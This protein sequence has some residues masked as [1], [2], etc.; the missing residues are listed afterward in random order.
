[1]P[2]QPFPSSFPI[3]PLPNVVLFPQ[4]RLPL[5][6]FEPRYREM[7]ADALA[8][9][10]VIGMVLLRPGESHERKRPAVFDVGCAGRISEARRLP[11]GRYYIL[12]EGSRRFRILREEDSSKPYRIVQAELLADP[13]F[14]SLGGEAR[15][16]LEQARN[17]LESH[18]L[19]LV[20]PSE[21]GSLD[22]LRER[23]QEIDPVRLTHMISFGLDCPFVEKQSLLEAPEPA[24][25]CR[26]LVQLLAFR[27]AESELADA[28]K[29]LN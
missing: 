20:R 1:M 19:A 7:T 4:A 2:T 9:D 21:P 27:R 12:L 6:V 10:R 26:L 29:S 28:P 23:L 8:G 11:G 14:E 3:F 5:N 25:R 15:A 17:D 16:A 13:V 22:A 18:L 24:A